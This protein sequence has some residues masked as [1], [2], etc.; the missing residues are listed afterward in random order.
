TV[1]PH[2]R[3]VAD[4]AAVL[5][6]IVSRTPDG[7]DPATAT[8]PLGKRGQPRPTLPDNYTAFLDPDGLRGARIGVARLGIDC[9]SPNAA[10]PFD[11]PLAAR[12]DAGATLINV[13]FQSVPQ[14]QLTVLLFDFK[15][16]VKTYLASRIGV[17]AAGGALADLI[18]FNNAHA[19]Q[20]LQFFGQ[21]IFELA[22][23]SS[24]RAALVGYPIVSVPMGFTFGL[25]VG[26]TFMGTAFSEPTLIKLASAFERVMQPRR[27]P[28][29][30]RTLPFDTTGLPSRIPS[31]DDITPPEHFMPELIEL[32]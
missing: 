15:R 3:T 12:T 22:F 29:F 20:E 19:A 2:A 31:R 14:R 9:A 7:R 1:G 30:L 6:V 26:I 16:D 5:N 11:K 4:A 8:S 17:P 10:A 28:R 21:E 23:G 32:M 27:P 13:T 18:A 25:P 24:S